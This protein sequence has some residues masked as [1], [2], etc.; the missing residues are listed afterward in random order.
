[1]FIWTPQTCYQLPLS[2]CSSFLLN[3]S[4]TSLG[5][6]WRGQLFW[7]Q[8]FISFYLFPS[9]DNL[10]L[11]HPLTVGQINLSTCVGLLDMSLHW[12]WSRLP[13]SQY[14]DCYNPVNYHE[15]KLS[16]WEH[17]SEL[18]VCSLVSFMAS[19]LTHLHKL[20]LML[21]GRNKL[22]SFYI[23]LHYNVHINHFLMFRCPTMFLPLSLR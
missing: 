23:S 6:Y 10:Q 7:K 17:F 4:I 1:M 18:F 12:P 21:C 8:A 11:A 3:S 20:G 13:F 15:N 19:L 2:L 22:S 14:K 9:K 16:S 5:R